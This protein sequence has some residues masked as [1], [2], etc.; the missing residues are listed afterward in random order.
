MADSETLESY[1][2]TC[3][4]SLLGRV[5]SGILWNCYLHVSTMIA[6]RLKFKAILATALIGPI[7]LSGS[8][9][10]Y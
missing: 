2:L 7:C 1:P 10:L 8:M 9:H 4:L 6:I 3:P 5:I